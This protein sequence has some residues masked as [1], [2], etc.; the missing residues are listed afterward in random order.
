MDNTESRTKTPP[1]TDPTHDE[2][3]FAEALRVEMAKRRLQQSA[4]AERAGMTRAALHRRMT[5]EAKIT[6]GQLQRLA[7]AIGVP[8]TSLI[9]YRPEVTTR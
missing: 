3:R 2:A 7:E 4:V 5:G 6:A 8:V 9:N 1:T